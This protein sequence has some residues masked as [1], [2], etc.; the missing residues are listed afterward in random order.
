MNR[1]IFIKEIQSIINVLPKQKAP[2]L[3]G[4][5]GQFYQTFKKEIIPIL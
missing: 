2:G 3:G 4:F 1:T 5:T